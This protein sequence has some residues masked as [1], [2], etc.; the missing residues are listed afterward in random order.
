MRCGIACCSVPIESTVRH[1]LAR[2]NAGEELLS[3]RVPADAGV[4]LSGSVPRRHGLGDREAFVRLHMPVGL[5]SALLEKIA[6]V[7]ANL[8]LQ[9]CSATRQPGDD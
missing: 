2:E 6:M 7:C 5:K 3:S 4:T 9:Q 1:G 8:W